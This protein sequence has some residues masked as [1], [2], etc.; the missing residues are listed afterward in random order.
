MRADL[1]DIDRGHPDARCVWGSVQGPA[2]PRFRIRRPTAAPMELVVV[3]RCWRGGTQPRIAQHRQ[4]DRTLGRQASGR[5]VPGRSSASAQACAGR[6]STGEPVRSGSNAPQ[7]SRSPSGRVEMVRE[8]GRCAGRSG[9]GRGEERREEFSLR[10]VTRDGVDGIKTEFSI[11]FH[12]LA[13]ANASLT[14]FN[15]INFDI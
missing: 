11:L 12:R 8:L 5:R 6:Y 1:V 2:A 10:D 15:R 4:A 3:P 7:A 14:V 13:G 9:G